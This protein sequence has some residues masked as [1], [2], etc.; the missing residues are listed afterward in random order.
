MLP[1]HQRMAELWILN[2]TRPLNESE[3]A[4]MQHCLKLNMDF[5]WKMAELQNKSLIASMTDDVKWQH[6]LCANIEELN[7]TGRINRDG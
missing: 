4:E 7:A 1:M 6:Q 3:L 5:V 2:R